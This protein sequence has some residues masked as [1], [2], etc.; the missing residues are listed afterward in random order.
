MTNAL[1]AYAAVLIGAMLIGSVGADERSE[2]SVDEARKEARVETTLSLNRSLQR[3]EIDVTVDG[4]TAVLTGTVDDT[5][6]S[7]L[8]EAL[9]MSVDG[10]DE[11]DNRLAIDAAFAGPASDHHRRSFARTVEDATIT[12]AV[13]SRLLWSRDA[14]GVNTAVQTRDG[15]VTL[16]GTAESEAAK[17]KAAQ[18]ARSAWGVSAVVNNI[19]I[20]AADDATG[21]APDDDASFGGTIS[22]AWITT[23]IRSSFLTSRWI[24]GTDIKIETN[25]G[26]VALSGELDSED[27]REM[28][29]EVAENIRGVRE[30]DAQN[31]TVVG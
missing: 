27:E 16:T 2:Q 11:V 13:R 8:A 29:I 23:K 9:A 3:S 19:E 5:L 24:S 17:E 31:L 7:D 26:V 21:T 28:A 1:N 4:T 10:I 20:R 30:V 22:D 18:L 15:R 6:H 25:D 14:D 12:T